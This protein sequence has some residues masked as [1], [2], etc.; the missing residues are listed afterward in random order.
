MH[1]V[2]FV[3]PL[4]RPVSLSILI[5]A[6]AP[7]GKRCGEASDLQALLCI[8]WF[9]LIGRNIFRESIKFQTFPSPPPP[10]TD[11]VTVNLSLL[12]SDQT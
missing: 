8:D 10:D 11:F 12:S 3:P 1:T 5:R 7:T 9:V 4:R 2:A 6:G